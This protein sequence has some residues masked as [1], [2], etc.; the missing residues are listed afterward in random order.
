V[1]TNVLGKHDLKAQFF[2]LITGCTL[3]DVAPIF[4]IKDNCLAEFANN[5]TEVLQKLI[6]PSR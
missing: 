1:A 4:N 2:A 3:K 6:S 5:T